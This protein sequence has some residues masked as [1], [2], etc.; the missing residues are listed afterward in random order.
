MRTVTATTLPDHAPAPVSNLR[1]TRRGDHVLYVGWSVPAIAYSPGASVVARLTRGYTP[2]PSPT[3]GYFVQVDSPR[4]ID[5]WASPLTANAVY[6][7][8]VWVQDHGVYSARRTVTVTTSKDVTPPRDLGSLKAEQVV[9]GTSQPQVRLTLGYAG[10]P[11]LAGARIVK[12]TRDT[13][14]G[15]TVIYLHGD[16]TSYLDTYVDKAVSFGTHYY[17]W[18]LP[19]DTAGNYARHYVG[20]SVLVHGLREASGTLEPPAN[21]SGFPGSVSLYDAS[22]QD[23]ADAFPDQTDGSWQVSVPPGK[24]TVCGSVPAD[25]PDLHFQYVPACWSPG[26]NYNWDGNTADFPAGA[27]QA[28]DLTDHDV[29]DVYIGLSTD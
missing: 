24:Y 20:A 6:T 12:N 21:Y 27:V 22:G 25:D 17:Y 9:T 13:T 18:A 15:G 10:D 26:G 28:L 7:F 11:S 1:V 5:A 16:P 23:V 4:P 29:T 14:T 2:A 3:S 8:A 19:Q